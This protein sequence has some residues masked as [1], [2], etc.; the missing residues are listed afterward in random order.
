[1]KICG[2]HVTAGNGE[3]LDKTYCGYFVFARFEVNEKTY[4]YCYLYK[5]EEEYE[6]RKQQFMDDAERA[7]EQ[8]M[9]RDRI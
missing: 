6:E 9:K 3:F 1:M 7:K 2:K 8:K 5:S 4:E